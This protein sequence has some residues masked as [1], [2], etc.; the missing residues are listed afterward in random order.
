MQDVERDR[1]TTVFD[2]PAEPLIRRVADKLKAMKE[3]TPP[4]WAPYVKTGITRERA[5]EGKDWWHVRVAAVL[6]KVY[7]NGPIGT[8]RLSAMF[9]GAVDRGS[10]PNIAKKGSRSIVRESLQQLEKA[11]LVGK[12]EANRGRIVLSKGKSLLD[13]MAHEVKMELGKKNPEL[14]KY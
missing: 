2:V 10:A 4:E 13:D 1:M 11:E 8:E 7:V 6:R 12:A 5:P 14:M 9:G 3:F